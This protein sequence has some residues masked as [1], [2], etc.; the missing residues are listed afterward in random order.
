LHVLQSRL[1]NR[2][3]ALN[4]DLY[5]ANLILNALCSCGKSDETA[6]HFLLHCYYIVKNYIVQRMSYPLSHTV[7][8]K[9]KKKKGKEKKNN[10]NKLS[11]SVAN[12]KQY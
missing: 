6:K 10:R 5:H 11:R 9:K 12:V 8:N 3:S 4:S 7:V 2:C 1:R